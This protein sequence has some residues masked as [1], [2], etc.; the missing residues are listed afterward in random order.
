MSSVFREIAADEARTL[1][2]MF[3]NTLTFTVTFQAVN[4]LV[5]DNGRS[6]HVLALAVCLLVFVL[7]W[8]QRLA[9]TST[10][11]VA[12]L[13]V[14]LIATTNSVAVQFVSNLVAVSLRSLFAA[15][16]LWWIIVFAYFALAV[17]AT[18]A[19]RHAV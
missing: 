12:K 1:L 8:V 17:L 2:P 14:S 16:S 15:Q 18:V 5:E 13:A 19:S 10:T 7:M 9:S 3:Q 4:A 11:A 6:T